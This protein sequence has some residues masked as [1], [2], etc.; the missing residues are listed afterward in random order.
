MERIENTTNTIVDGVIWKGLLKFF[1]PIMLG[2]L[3]QPVSYTHLKRPEK[4]RTGAPVL[5]LKGRRRSGAEPL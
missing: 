1:F 2:T 3:F 5:H 4:R